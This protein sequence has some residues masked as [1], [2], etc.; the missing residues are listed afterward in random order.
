MLGRT[1]PGIGISGFKRPLD[2]CLASLFLL[3][4]LPVMLSLGIL[5]LL[6]TG[7]VFTRVACSSPRFYRRRRHSGQAEIFDLLN[8]NTRKADGRPFRFGV[9]LERWGGQHLPEWLHVMKGDLALAGLKP[10]VDDT[11]EWI[12][13]AWQWEEK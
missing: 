12:P 9:W 5:L 13:E 4:T 10:V 6:T 1:D 11:D 7:R 3:L 2:F 8:F